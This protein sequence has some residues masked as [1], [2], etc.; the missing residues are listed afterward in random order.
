MGL[1]IAFSLTPNTA[2]KTNKPTLLYHLFRK[3]N[4]F[5]IFNLNIPIFDKESLIK[6]FRKD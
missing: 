3:Y 4:A 1:L 2:E 5:E 6:N